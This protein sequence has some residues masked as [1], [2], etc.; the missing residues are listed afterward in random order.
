MITS[1]GGGPGGVNLGL[2]GIDGLGG[3]SGL[4]VQQAGGGGGGTATA[5]QGGGGGNGSALGAS[6]SPAINGSATDIHENP[7][8]SGNSGAAG[9]GGGGGGGGGAPGGSGGNGGPGSPGFI[10]IY[11]LSSA[12]VIA[13]SSTGSGAGPGNVTVPVPGWVLGREQ[14]MSV[15]LDGP[16]HTVVN[17]LDIFDLKGSQLRSPEA[18]GEPRQQQSGSRHPARSLGRAFTIR[19]RS[20]RPGDGLASAWS[21]EYGESRPWSA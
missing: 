3:G 21:Q 12:G 6:V 1:G 16:W 9:G 20:R 15:P 2:F 10:V 5:T 7:I 18:S 17:E 8:L 13:P 11:F 4:G 19:L 14:R